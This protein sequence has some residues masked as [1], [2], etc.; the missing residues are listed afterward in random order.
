MKKHA[1]FGRCPR[2][3]VN[4]SLAVT[5]RQAP[6]A[7]QKIRK[8]VA[9]NAS[10]STADCACR[11][12]ACSP[13]KA[14]AVAVVICISANAVREPSPL[15]PLRE[16]GGR[17]RPYWRRHRMHACVAP[18]EVC[19]SFELVV[20]PS[21]DRRNQRTRTRTRTGSAGSAQ[22]PSAKFPAGQHDTLTHTDRVAPILEQHPAREMVC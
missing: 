22:I 21:D 2:S 7:V 17:Y 16:T 6:R 14:R 13:G 12:G 1:E 8:Q 18:V 20:A 5:V 15:S 9:G 11:H 3:S 4:P 10:L 19:T